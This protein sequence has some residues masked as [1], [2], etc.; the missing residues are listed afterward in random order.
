MGGG[1]SAIGSGCRPRSGSGRYPGAARG[2]A[3]GANYPV[4]FSP[5]VA[6][7]ILVTPTHTAPSHHQVAVHPAPAASRPRVDSLRGLAVSVPL[8]LYLLPCAVAAATPARAA[9]QDAETRSADGGASPYAVVAPWRD[10]LVELALAPEPGGSRGRDQAALRVALRP[11]LSESTQAGQL[12]YRGP[13]TRATI[14]A[15]HDLLVVPVIHAGVEPF[16]RAVSVTVDAGGRLVGRREHRLSSRIGGGYQPTQVLACTDGDGVM[17]MWQEVRFAGGAA[18]ARTFMARV[19]AD[20]TLSEEARE[21]P[22]PWGIAAVVDNGAGYHLALFFDGQGPGQTRLCLVTLSR[23]GQPEQ[24]PWWASAPELIDEVKL[25]RI[26]GRVVAAYRGGRDG[27]ALR[28]LGSTAVGQW[29]VQPGPPTDLGSIA[30][31]EEMLIVPGALGGEARV[32]RVRGSGAAA[33]SAVDES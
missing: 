19:A 30:E 20:G 23:N 2:Q 33:P 13:A 16:V 32:V 4:T 8:A 26:G 27:R 21:I 17:V 24:H 11:R 28:L 29:G 6:T 22:V 14:V 9:A 10:G 7:V 31:D 5:V 15:S 18:D 25:A 1:A 12:L 3:A